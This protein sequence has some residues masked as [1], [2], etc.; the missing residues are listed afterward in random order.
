MIFWC[1][2]HIKENINK[3]WISEFFIKLQ[4]LSM[5]LFIEIKVWMYAFMY[6]YPENLPAGSMPKTQDRTWQ[7]K[8]YLTAGKSPSQMEMMKVQIFQST[9]RWV[10]LIFNI[11]G[12]N[13]CSSRLIYW[14]FPLIYSSC[15]NVV[16]FMTE[17]QRGSVNIG[18]SFKMSS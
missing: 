7:Q 9:V 1:N 13:Y 12:Q 4:K 2:V 14:Y 10:R 11:L 3:L 6:L 17:S 18:L 16:G 8:V 15:N 5:V